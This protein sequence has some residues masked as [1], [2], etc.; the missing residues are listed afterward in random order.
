MCDEIPLIDFGRFLNGNKEER[1][2]VSKEIGDACRKIGFFYISNHGIPSST[3]ADVYEQAKR[4]FSQSI[5]EKQK[6]YIGSCPYENNRGYTPFYEEK[7]SLKGD[8]KEGFDLAMELPSDDPDRVLRGAKLYGPNF[9]P[10][11]LPGFSFL[12]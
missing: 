2:N 11:N 12:N 6:L 8:L 1:L 7:L 4:F 9:W 3:I 5:E 10:D